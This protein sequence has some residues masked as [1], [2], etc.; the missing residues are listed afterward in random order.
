MFNKNLV[1]L[2][3][4]RSPKELVV[5]GLT[6]A[7]K[8]EKAGSSLPQDEAPILPN[9]RKINYLFDLISHLKEDLED[10]LKILGAGVFGNVHESAVLINK[11]K[12]RIEAGA[13]IGPLVVID[14]SNGPVVIREKTIVHPHT[15]LRG[16][17][18][19]GKDC[20]IA[21]ELVH[22]VFLDYSNKGH[23]GFIGHSYI[24]SFVNLG[25]GTTNSNLK[26]NY[27]NVGIYNDGTMIDSGQTFLGTFIGDHTKTAIGT[28]IYTGCIIGV[29]A[30]LFGE[31][32]YKKMIPSF[33]WGTK[34]RQK[35]EQAIETAKAAMARRGIEFSSKDEALF[36][37]IFTSTEFSKI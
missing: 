24:G 27:T 2:T 1:P 8:F 19:I 23:Y 10:D 16:P 34:G 13:T 18:Y 11:D 36:M 21:G 9:G 14:A 15:I 35:V 12:I 26:N 25:A 4:F 28:M 29:S 32:Y 5:G 30:N 31:P 7:E 33:A 3:Y 17:I 22:S 6:I 37:E 20:R